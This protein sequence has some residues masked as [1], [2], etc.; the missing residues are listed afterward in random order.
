MRVAA[1]GG[2]AETLVSA[3]SF[4]GGS[5]RWP[6]WTTDG[7]SVLFTVF[8]GSLTSARIGAFSLKTGESHIVADGTYPIRRPL[9]LT[10]NTDATKLKPAIKSFIDFVKGP[11]GQKV[12]A[13]L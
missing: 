13:S 12:I 10:Y 5:L 9:Y 7:S 1:A 6:V 3:K 2:K 8:S 11:D 4:N